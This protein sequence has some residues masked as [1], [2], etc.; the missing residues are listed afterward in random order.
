MAREEIRLADLVLGIGEPGNLRDDI[1]QASSIAGGVFLSFEWNGSGDIPGA[2]AATCRQGSTGY[3]NN[4][5][6]TFTAVLPVVA[7]DWFQLR[8]NFSSPAWNAILANSRSW[9]A[10]EVVET[11]DAADPPADITVFRPGQPGANELLLRV[12]IA[13]R[14][15]L[16]I[17]LAG[18][19]GSA[20]TAAT[21]ETDFDIR[22]NGT[23]FA[24]MRF[25]AGADTATFIAATE[26]VLEP[27]DVLS[28]VAPATADPTL[29]DVGFS[30]AGAL[31]V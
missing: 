9:L 26:T 23:S 1:R 25:A 11:T 3:T 7:G 2:A 14:T 28:V 8:V 29:A 24:T 19:R 4:D 30:L 31:V 18:S 22:R 20:G 17:D 5:F 12:P 15:R 21:A 6:A 16:P 27:G 10:L 13:R